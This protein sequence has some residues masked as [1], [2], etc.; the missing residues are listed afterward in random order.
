MAF[1][2]IIKVKPTLVQ[3]LP[4]LIS[5]KNHALSALTTELRRNESCITKQHS[6]EETSKAAAA[7][8]VFLQEMRRLYDEETILLLKTVIVVFAYFTK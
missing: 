1:K 7:A 5:K 4:T 2:K 3:V 6:P 8:I